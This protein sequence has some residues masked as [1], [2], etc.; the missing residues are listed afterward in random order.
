MTFGLLLLQRFGAF[1][2]GAIYGIRILGFQDGAFQEGAFLDVSL[3]LLGYAGWFWVRLYGSSWFRIFASRLWIVVHDVGLLIWRVHP[4]YVG[5]GEWKSSEYPIDSEDLSSD[6]DSSSISSNSIEY[7]EWESRVV[8]YNQHTDRILEDVIIN[9]PNLVIQD[10]PSRARRVYRDRERERVK[11]YLDWGVEGVR[12]VTGAV[13]QLGWMFIT[14]WFSSLSIP[15][16]CLDVKSD[17]WYGFSGRNI[18]DGRYC[19]SCE[20]DDGELV[21]LQVEWGVRWREYIFDPG[22]TR[23]KI[24][25]EAKNGNGNVNAPRSCRTVGRGVSS[26]HSDV[27]STRNTLSKIEVPHFELKEDPSFSMNPNV[28]ITIRPLNY[29][30]LSTQGYKWCLKQE[31]AQTLTFVGHPKSR[32]TFDHVVCETIDQETLF[33]MV[34]LPMVEN[35][36]SGY[37][38]CIF[39]YGQTGSGKTHTMLGEINELEVKPS[40]YWGMIPRMFESLFARIIMEEESRVD[41]RL[42]YTSKCSYLEIYNEQITDLLDPS[43]TNLQLRENVKKG[44]YVENLTEFEVHTVRDILRLLIRVFIRSIDEVALTSCLYISL[45]IFV[46]IVIRWGK[47]STSNLH[48]ARLNLVD[49]PGSERQK[50]SGAEGE[51]LKE[52]A[53]INKSLSTLGTTGKMDEAYRLGTGSKWVT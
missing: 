53:N 18:V 6:S 52:A 32:F 37:N 9:Y 7:H 14:G 48:F 12:K 50:T 3:L 29:M 8:Q 31:S 4:G 17:G 35:C 46:V 47:D 25:N 49:L 13:T 16:A 10:Q 42:A 22:L 2:D 23:A 44:V 34:G 21:C 27:N 43:S 24:R 15:P 28:L 33:R 41:E 51:R 5:L 20:G 11:L 26:G 36:L 38:S 19:R 1:H 39:A 30:E 40:P 45:L